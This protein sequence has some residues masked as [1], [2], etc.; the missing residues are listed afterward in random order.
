MKLCALV[1]RAEQGKYPRGLRAD[2]SALR[3]DTD[4]QRWHFLDNFEEETE[5]Q[6][7]ILKTRVCSLEFGFEIDFRWK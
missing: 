6:K 7:E 3:H 2:T 1:A 4:P 5:E